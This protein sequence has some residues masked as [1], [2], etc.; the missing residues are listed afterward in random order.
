LKLTESRTAIA[1]LQDRLDE[2]DKLL[3][4]R[5]AELTAAQAFLTRVD[6]V[7]DAEVV[8][9][10]ENLNALIDSASGAISGA[11]SDIWDQREPVSETVTGEFDVKK[12]RDAFGHSMFEQ[13]AARN[14]VAVTLAINSHLIRFVRRVV[15]GW[16]GGNAAGIL[17][18][19]YG[20]IS[21]KGE[22]DACV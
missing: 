11:I 2:R 15:S 10:V 1:R 18:E 20:M 4:E 22:S 13:I 9:M 17:G 12:I 5:T 7:S 6:A 19:I 16:G 8:G 21:T 14:S 3:S